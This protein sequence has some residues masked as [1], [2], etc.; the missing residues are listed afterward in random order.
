MNRMNNENKPT[1]QPCRVIRREHSLIMHAPGFSY[2]INVEQE[3]RAMEWT[4]HLTG[5]AISLGDGPELEVDVEDL[6]QRISIT[7]WR[8]TLSQSFMSEP[9]RETGF[10]RG[11]FAS[12]FDDSEWTGRTTPVPEKQCS[13]NHYYWART[14][15]VL[16]EDN[17]GKTVHVVLGGVGLMDFRYMRIFIN[18]MEVGTRIRQS[19]WE[20][21]GHIELSAGDESYQ[22]LRFGTD[23][24]IALQLS[25]LMDRSKELDAIDPQQSKKMTTK[26]QWPFQFEQYLTVGGLY[27]PVTFQVVDVQ[28][29]TGT[30]QAEVAVRLGNAEEQIGAT[31]RYEWNA[32]SNMLRKYTTLHND[33]KQD[34]RILHVR[35]GM[36]ATNAVVT[37]GEQ[38]F[39]VYVADQGY[40]SLEHPSGWAVGQEG[41]VWLKQYP[42]RLLGSGEQFPC[43]NAVIGVSEQGEA[44]TVFKRLLSARMRRVIRKHDQA[45]AIFEPFGGRQKE[46]D[47]KK[48]FGLFTQTEAYLLDNIDRMTR[49]DQGNGSLFDYYCVDFWHDVRGNLMHAEP[50]E[51]PNDLNLIVQKIEQNDMKLGLWIDSSMCKWSIGENPEAQCSKTT[52]DDYATEDP[53]SF[54]RASEPVKSMYESAFIHHIRHNRMRLLKVDNLQAICYNPHHHNHLPGIYSTEAIQQSV[55]GFLTMLDEECPDLF[56]M[57][58][59]GYRSPW[60]LLH[61]DTLFESGLLMEAAHPGQAPTLYLRDSTIQAVD[62]GLFWCRDIPSLAKDSLGV[63]MSDWAWNSSIGRERWLEAMVMDM[64]RGNLLI[65]PWSDHEWLSA[66]EWEQMAQ[67]IAIHKEHADCFLNSKPILGNPWN[68][69]AYG[70]CCSNGERAFLALNNCTWSDATVTLRLGSELDLLDGQAWHVYRL[71]PDRVQLTQEATTELTFHD[72]LVV[73]LRPFEIVLLEIV[74]ADLSIQPQYQVAV[75]ASGKFTEVS[76]TVKVQLEQRIM[77]DR[78]SIQL[79]GE[80][81]ATSSGGTLVATCEMFAEGE[82]FLLQNVGSYFKAS[83]ELDGQ[84]LVSTPVVR[85]RTFE[86]SWQAW[87]MEIDPSRESSRWEMSIDLLVTQ[88]ITIQCSAHYIPWR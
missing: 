20:E 36:Y 48:T 34:K 47:E 15:V 8:G 35:L 61:A 49:H 17:R 7:G 39:P 51:F 13:A 37:E 77:Q 69:E 46:P 72:E 62:Q 78:R 76:R 87:R 42:G 2:A 26:A 59:W 50:Q 79:I 57:L 19:R 85:D 30:D 68:N 3:L 74:P 10:I 22:H 16:S 31:I 40:M 58:Y 64:G 56:L 75:A 83:A 44:R 53:V 27:R 23:N 73:A 38:G 32:D 9:D 82:A 12:E 63:W 80:L 84:L 70:Y 28:V 45:L 65:Q 29:R 1:H 54:C 21:P 66:A 11:Y 25:G 5:R 41:H 86:A 43:M 33:G 18:G 52:T 55:V 24:V 60:W 67:L 71:C 6:E 88:P 81:P 14:H 4:N